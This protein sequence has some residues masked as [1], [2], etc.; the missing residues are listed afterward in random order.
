MSARAWVLVLCLAGCGKEL[1]RIPLQQQDATGSVQ[2][3]VEGGQPLA[4]WTDLDVEWEGNFAIVYNI[5]LVDPS[6]AVVESVTCN[7]HNVS[8][9]L[10]SVRTTNSLRYQ[11]KMTDCTL[12]PKISGSHTIRARVTVS[13]QPRKLT[14]RD[15]SLVIKK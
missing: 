1:A 15:I 7:P 2:L 4:L 3:A 5:D 14:L 12:T 9:R 8:V 6:G 10:H 13:T 11:G